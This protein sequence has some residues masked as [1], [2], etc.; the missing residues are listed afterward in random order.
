[1]TGNKWVDLLLVAAA[2]LTALG[3]VWRK[4]IKP[5]VHA[6][7]TFERVAPVLITIGEQFQANGGNSLRDSIN[8]IEATQKELHDY[9]HDWR[10]KLSNEITKLVLADQVVAARLEM[11]AATDVVKI[12]KLDDLAAKVAPMPGR[13]DEIAATAA[14]ADVQMAE[15]REAQALSADDGTDN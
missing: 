6:L 10:H 2:V 5:I 9:S 8:R 4:A 7:A 3:V 1:M 13:L 15:H 11:M 12:G 14:M